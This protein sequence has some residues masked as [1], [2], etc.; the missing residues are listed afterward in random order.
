MNPDGATRV[1][2]DLAA[3]VADARPFIGRTHVSSQLQAA[4]DRAS[5]QAMPALVALVG[6]SGAGKTRLLERIGQDAARRDPPWELHYASLRSPDEGPFA[7]VSRLLLD[8]FGITPASS[9]SAA[10]AQMASS[11]GTAL[12]TGDLTRVTEVTHLLGYVAGVPFPGSPVL[13]ALGAKPT[14][15]RERAAEAVASFVQ[16]EARQRPQLWLLDEVAQADPA[17]WQLVAALLQ[18]DAPLALVTTGGPALAEAMSQ[19]RDEAV[20]IQLAPLSRQE[21]VELIKARLPDLQELPEALLSALLRRSGGNPGSL[22]SLVSELQ[23]AGLFV[24]DARGTHLDLTR[25]ETGDLP[26]T[27][28]DAVRTRL[29][30]LTPAQLE[31]VEN[32]AIIG[33]RFWEGAILALSRNAAPLPTSTRPGVVLW[34]DDGDTFDLRGTL[35]Q[36]TDAGVILSI[37]TSDTPGLDEY[38]FRRGG[39]R[40]VIYDSLTDEHKLAGHAAVARWLGITGAGIEGKAALLAA[41][42]ERARSASRAA[43]AYLEAASIERARMRTTMALRYVE[44]ALPLLDPEDPAALLDALH[45]H[46]SLLTTLGRYD[47]AYASFDELLRLAWKLDTRSKGGAALNRIAR[48]HRQRGENHQALEHLRMALRLFRAADDLPGVASTHDDMAQIHR[49]HG[50]LEP[51]FAAASEA[52]KIRTV[53]GDHRGQGL[54]LTTLGR[55]E[56]D[57]GN[58]KQAQSH[59]SRALSLRTEAGDHEGAI[60]TRISLGRLAYQRGHIGEAIRIFRDALESAREM[61]HRRFESYLL[62]HLGEATMASGD[63][64][65]A[66]A[67]L[68]QAKELATRM[69]DQ[70]ALADVERNLGLL[71]LQ[72]GDQS[73]P[74][75]LEHALELASTYGTPNAIAHAHRARAQLQ[76]RSVFDPSNHDPGAAER[77]YRECL[78]IFEETGNRPQYARTQAELGLHLL[79][80]QQLEG[81]RTLLAAAEL[82][83]QELGLPEARRVGET[84]ARMTQA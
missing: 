79:E 81:A 66:A 62:G 28:A 41:H 50:D 6:E 59:L 49:L 51:A 39:F 64:E 29:A 18:T 83:L 24:A 76:A 34:Q 67:Y 25:L 14:V 40:T 36:L 43:S 82:A 78:R 46:G 37:A 23:E 75:T 7:P 33:E 42:L 35:Q 12:K 11:V 70:R 9:P 63:T 44:K 52:L 60:Q 69:R 57:R 45:Q 4:L 73:A 71:A 38:T 19:F 65:H 26:L 27:A 68:A 53:T 54:S 58:F 72:R 74:Q 3:P 5:Q 80:R 77:S 21:T 47:E 55:I 15:L 16:A 22:D 48:I 1:A 2:Q 8:R 32:A 30:S 13:A 31:V 17:F 84:L 20:L 61:D 56:L 10:R